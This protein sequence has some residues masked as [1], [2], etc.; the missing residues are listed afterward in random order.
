MYFVYKMD[1]YCG[2]PYIIPVAI[3]KNEEDF[4]KFNDIADDKAIQYEEVNMVDMNNI[5]PISYI[6]FIYRANGET[7]YK[8]V[9]TNTLLTTESKC[10]NAY[11]FNDSVHITKVLKDEDDINTLAEKLKE[12]S[13]NFLLGKSTEELESSDELGIKTSS[14]YIKIA[15][16]DLFEKF[17]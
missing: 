4:A 15:A 1:E 10:N 17:L 3:L 2:E 9:I 11:T 14:L 8:K 5:K 6:D 12:I 13:H 16:N 7:T